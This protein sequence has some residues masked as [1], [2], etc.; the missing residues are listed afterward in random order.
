VELAAAPNDERH[1]PTRIWPDEGRL[2]LKKPILDSS[3]TADLYASETGSDKTGPLMLTRYFYSASG[4]GQTDPVLAP[5]L[6]FIS[7]AELS[8]MGGF[9][10]IATS[11]LNDFFPNGEMLPTFFGLPTDFLA[12]SMSIVGRGTSW[13]GVQSDISTQWP[14]SGLNPG[15]SLHS[16]D[17]YTCG[18]GGDATMFN[19]YGPNG[20]MTQ[21]GGMDASDSLIKVDAAGGTNEQ[22][23]SFDIGQAGSPTSEYQKRHVDF[24]SYGGLMSTDA[25]LSFAQK[26]W[27]AEAQVV[28][29][30]GAFTEANVVQGSFDSGS[31]TLLSGDRQVQMSISAHGDGNNSLELDQA[32]WAGFSGSAWG[33]QF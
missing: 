31:E 27:D 32:N 9:F 24:S 23:A 25:F 2:R 11:M 17:I 14:D 22:G 3:N 1:T 15:D 20:D 18:I 5:T 33:S 13:T 4:D 10:G 7:K 19:Y 30:M 28:P 26:L 29:G 16:R 12:A 21:L 8:A 6:S